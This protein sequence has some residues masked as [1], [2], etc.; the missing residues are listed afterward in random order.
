MIMKRINLKRKLEFSALIVALAMVICSSARADVITE[1]NQNAQQAMLTANTSPIAA[2][3]VMAIVQVA[4]FDA[5][6]GIERRYNPVHV[7]FNAPPGASRR[8]AAI[9]AACA[10]DGAS[11][12]TA[13]V[14]AWWLR[15]RPQTKRQAL[16]PSME[17]AASI[18]T[19]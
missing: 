17:G 6:N 16:R 10:L 14:A 15:R 3:R 19:S 7:D 18:R 2:S 4:V 8:A 12:P 11:L 1:W 9:Q 13:V 5:V